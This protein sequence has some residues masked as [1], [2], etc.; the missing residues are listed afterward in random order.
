MAT[1]TVLI[2][3][4]ITLKATFTNSAGSVADPDTLFC[5]FTVYNENE[6]QIDT[7]VADR[8]SQ[9]IYTY[10][11]LVPNARDVVYFLE[12][13][14]LFSDDPQLSRMKIRAKFK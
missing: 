2:G 3:D 6:Q 10:D 12:M 11:W 5:V 8:V 13:K 14:G 1:E 9:G 4:T 7:G